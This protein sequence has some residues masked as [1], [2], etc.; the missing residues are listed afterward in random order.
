MEALYL[1]LSPTFIPI[2]SAKVKLNVALLATTVETNPV[3]TILR[4]A[5]LTTLAI[6]PEDVDV[7]T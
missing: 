1:T 6:L 4:L 5:S 7:T 2:I 3:F